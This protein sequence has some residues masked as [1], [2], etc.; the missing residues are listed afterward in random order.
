M[1][2]RAHVISAYVVMYLH[3]HV[4]LMSYAKFRESQS[5]T[6]VEVRRH[7]GLN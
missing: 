7:T 3:P 5:L 6:S 4:F 2:K 1:Y